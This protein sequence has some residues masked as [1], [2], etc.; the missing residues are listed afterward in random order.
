MSCGGGRCSLTATAK[1]VQEI[2]SANITSVGVLDSPKEF[3][4]L[5]IKEKLFVG[6]S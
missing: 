6:S 2:A 5:D 3:R 4:Q 1:D